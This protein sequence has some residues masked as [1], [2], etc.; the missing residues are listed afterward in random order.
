MIVLSLSVAVSHWLCFIMIES[1]II[2][3]IFLSFLQIELPIL[4]FNI[5]SQQFSI[6]LISILS[7]IVVLIHSYLKKRFIDLR[8]RF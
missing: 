4:I 6:V 1:M 8:K 3:L 5:V 7:S 2:T